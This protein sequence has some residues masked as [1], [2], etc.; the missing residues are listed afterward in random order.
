MN[1]WIHERFSFA[2][3]FLSERVLSYLILLVFLV[4][5]YI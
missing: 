2:W 5:S 3:K 4:V 1:E